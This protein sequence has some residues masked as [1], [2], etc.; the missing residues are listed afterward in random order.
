[1]LNRLLTII[2]AGVWSACLALAQASGATPQA[3]VRDRVEPPPDR[4][5]VIVRVRQNVSVASFLET[6]GARIVRPLPPVDGFVV[7]V[8]ARGL[9]VLAR[10][11]RIVSISPD[12]P[13]RAA[14]APGV[15]DERDLR[16]RLLDAAPGIDGE[17]IGIALIDS[18]ITAWHDDLSAGGSGQRVE[19]FVDFVGHGP[20][21]YDDYGHGTHVAGIVAGNGFDSE[22]ARAGVA[23]GARLVAL[24]VLDAHGYGR[25]SDVIDAID[26]AIL[27]RE[28]YNIRILNVSVAA[29]VTESY[30]TDPLT[31]AAR[32]AVQAG[33][34]VVAA[35]GNLGLD[36]AGEPVYGGITA[37]GNA[38]WVITVGAADREDLA[39][40]RDGIAAFSSR[41]PTRFDRR[42]KPDLVAPGVGIAS[43][44]E[45]GSTL[46]SARP[47][48]RLWGS[49]QTATPPYFRMSGT[50]MAAPAVSGTIALMLQVNPSLTPAAVLDILRFTARPSPRYDRLTQGAG[51][52][53]IRAAVEVAQALSSTAAP[54]NSGASR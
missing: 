42:A 18:G 36:A 37:P 25:I 41:G 27:S 20:A 1:M 44:S 24:K 8:P 10:D 13:V 6:L 23:P 46:Y 11:P 47:Q 28:R 22:G 14:N 7:E 5:R 40:R 51:R 30:M 17:G 49:I 50:S 4:S 29:D 48:M 16:P 45:P 33:L 9:A 54:A 21:P 15:A 39:D 3:S 38:P 43:L 26:F 2:V 32:R 12:R 35:A 34:V 52:L 53:D 19:R 31:L